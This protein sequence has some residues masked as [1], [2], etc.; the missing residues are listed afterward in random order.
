MPRARTTRRFLNKRKLGNIVKARGH[1]QTV[2][3]DWE[4]LRI[5]TALGQHLGRRSRIV[6]RRPGWMPE[7]VYRFMLDSIAADVTE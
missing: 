6:L 2:I 5:N 7:R 1:V 3:S 4:A